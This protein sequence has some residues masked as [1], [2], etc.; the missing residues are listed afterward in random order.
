MKKQAFLKLAMA[1]TMLLLTPLLTAYPLQKSIAELQQDP[2]RYHNQEV[3]VYG[4]VVRSIALVLG[5]GMFEIDDGTGRM[6]V[7]SER[8]GVPARGVQVW[9]AGVVSPAVS[10]VGRS[11]AT[12]MRETQRR[13]YD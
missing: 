2:M 3:I 1:C 13:R 12:V 10:I 4:T 8:L 5:A 7:Y 11:F 9:V 6:W